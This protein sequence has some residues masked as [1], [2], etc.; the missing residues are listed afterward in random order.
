MLTTNTIEASQRKVELPGHAFTVVCMLLFFL[1]AFCGAFLIARARLYWYIEHPYL[2]YFVDLLAPEENRHF[3]FV[4]T[5]FGCL[6]ALH[7]LRLLE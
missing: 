1:H 6:G 2:V 3:K 7:L 4:G 5:S